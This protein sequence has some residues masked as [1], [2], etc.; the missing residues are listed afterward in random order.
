MKKYIIAS[1]LI[2]GFSIAE[3]KT[4]GG[5][6]S[7]FSKEP[8]LEMYP[9][10]TGPLLAPSSHNVPYGHVNIEPYLYWTQYRGIYDNN[11]KFAAQ[12]HFTVYTLSV[13]LQ[14]GI[15][16]YTEFDISPQAYYSYSQGQSSLQFADLPL[17]LSFQLLN[18]KPGK[19]W[20]PAIKLRFGANAPTGKFDHLKPSKQ[21]TDQSG[22]GSWYPGVGLV[23]GNLF[24]LSGSHFLAL[25][26]FFNY[27][28]PV[29]ASVRGSNI[30]GGTTKTRGTI[31]PGAGFTANLG[32]EYSIS[33]PWTLALDILYNYQAKNRF[34]GYDGGAPMTSPSSANYSLAPAIEYN[35]SDTIGLI[36]GSWFTI[37]GRNTAQ[38]INFI[39][40]LNVYI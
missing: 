27:N 31:Y 14:F 3:A 25:R 5:G 29:G 16:P 8:S 9:W 28:I 18:D 2:L 22:I 36:G 30:Y 39:L 13:P 32:L 10:L 1:L 15:L 26:Y 11:W 7:L 24:H 20:P 23:F 6:P 40:A 35:F 17:A 12:H 34:S 38:F 4:T 33:Q 21:G 37:A 19:P